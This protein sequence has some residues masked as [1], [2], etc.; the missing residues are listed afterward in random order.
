MFTYFVF[1]PVGFWLPFRAPAAIALLMMAIVGLTALGLFCR[2]LIVSHP[3]TAIS[4][5]EERMT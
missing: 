5:G 4:N 2:T 3:K 1:G